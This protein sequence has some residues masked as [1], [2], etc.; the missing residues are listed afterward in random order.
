MNALLQAFHTRW[1]GYSALNALLPSERFFTGHVPTGTT[2]PYATLQIIQQEVVEETALGEALTQWV[3]EVA[4]RAESLANVVSVVAEVS[5]AYHEH[6]FGM[7]GI[8]HCV[9]LEND[10]REEPHGIW[11]TSSRFEVLQ[12]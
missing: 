6:T 11:V 8:L 2:F 4:V 7:S 3:L 10:T 12:Q 1:A 5:N 9:F